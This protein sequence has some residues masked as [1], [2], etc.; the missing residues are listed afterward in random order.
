MTNRSRSTIGTV[1]S[2]N[3]GAPRAVQV[4]EHTILTAIWKRPV[5][6]LVPL[7]GVNFRGDDQADRTVHGGADKAV[8][9]YAIEDTEW[10]ETE[11]ERPLG[12]GAFGENLIVR[13]LPAS[14]AVIGERWAVGTAL[15]QVSQP[16]LPCFKLALRMD[17]PRFL[18]R[19]AKAG[20]PGTYL[21]VLREGDIAARDAINVVAR[22]AHG[23]TSALVSRA[24]LGEHQLLSLALTAPELP[25][26]LR[27]WMQERAE[28]MDTRA[29]MSFSSRPVQRDKTRS[30]ESTVM[31]TPPGAARAVTKIPAQDL[32]RARRFYRDRLGLEPVEER[33]SGLRYLRGTTEFHI[34]A[35]SGA[36]SGRSTQMA[37]EV[38][39]LDQTVADLQAR[40]LEFATFDMA[41]FEVTDQIV[42]APDNYPSKGAGERGRVLLRQ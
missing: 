12:P 32:D 41:G 25:R 29:A 36:A 26:D 16:R 30:M 3:V 17:D 5:E 9:A 18:K 14:E 35:S 37:F 38:E 24:L 7:R 33:T 13:G 15:L 1:A 39:D 31:T 28:V 40:G 10:W 22:P 21:R 4:N 34:F 23:V 20:R 42:V 2:L 8:Y 6:G 27:A 11:L 19:F